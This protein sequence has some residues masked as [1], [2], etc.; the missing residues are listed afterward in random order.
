M[1]IDKVITRF[2]HLIIS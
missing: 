1:G 2:R